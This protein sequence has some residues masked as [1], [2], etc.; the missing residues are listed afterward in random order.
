ML[1]LLVR[2]HG[3]TAVKFLKL[4]L[5]VRLVMQCL[6]LLQLGVLLEQFTDQ[7]YNLNKYP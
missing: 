6:D 4:V 5:V 3:M 2:M 7:E 1:V